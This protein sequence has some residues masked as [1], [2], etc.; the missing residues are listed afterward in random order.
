M[1]EQKHSDQV[2]AFIDGELKGEELAS[3]QA[4]MESD[5]ELAAEVNG[6]RLLVSDLAAMPAVETPS[7]FAEGVLARVADLPIPGS[8]GEAIEADIVTEAGAAGDIPGLAMS[9]LVGPEGLGG[10]SRFFMRSFWL[11]LPAG[12]LVAAGLAFGFSHMLGPDSAGPPDANLVAFGGVTGKVDDGVV[13]LDEEALETDADLEVALERGGDQQDSAPMLRRPE[14][15]VRSGSAAGSKGATPRKK[16]SRKRREVA[17]SVVGEEGVF[18]ADWESDDGVVVADDPPE[19]SGTDFAEEDEEPL[20]LEQTSADA[21][22]AAEPTAASELEFAEEPSAGALSNIND[23]T[24]SGEPIEDNLSPD[25]DVELLSEEVERAT[26]APKR[27]IRARGALRK[28]DTSFEASSAPASPAA[29]SEPSALKKNDEKPTSA[30][31]A[32]AN[33]L[34][35]VDR[36]RANRLVQE[37]RAVRGCDAELTRSPSRFVVRIKYEGEALDRL[38]STLERAGKL[39]LKGRAAQGAGVHELRLEVV[40]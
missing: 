14:P 11:K 19:P 20:Y 22:V 7:G 24:M 38:M 37:I 23:I 15:S 6:L 31:D 40:W 17:K 33:V 26:R 21:E 16:E 34:T 10:L 9:A 2:S 35:V 32:S 1:S 12:A 4:A 8:A 39:E 3:F 27:G 29:A 30:V 28:A 36:A 13:A 25:A 5:P 18:E